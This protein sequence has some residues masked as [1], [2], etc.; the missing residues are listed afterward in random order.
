M[1]FGFIEQI[2]GNNLGEREHG[3]LQVLK[4]IPQ[5]CKETSLT[6][7]EKKRKCGKPM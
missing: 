4:G 3:M 5:K 2:N 1:T 7:T 6:E